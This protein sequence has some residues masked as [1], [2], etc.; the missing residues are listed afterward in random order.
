MMSLSSSP[1]IFHTIRSSLILFP[2]SHQSCRGYSVRSIGINP[3]GT[4]VYG[5]DVYSATGDAYG[6]PFFVIGSNPL[7]TTQVRRLYYV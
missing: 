5:T 4:Q 3:A 1:C 7:P 2:A 6:P